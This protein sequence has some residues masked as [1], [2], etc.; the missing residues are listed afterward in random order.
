M[1]EFGEALHN[2][3]NRRN[4]ARKGW[5]GKG[6][7][8]LIIDGDAINQAIIDSYGNPD[9]IPSNPP[10]QDAIYMR[11]ADNKLVPW[12]ASQSDI[13]AADWYVVS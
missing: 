2:L 13:L 8:I 10:M 1:S 3:R 12:V 7:F 6:M 4:V 11:T 9:D 5:N